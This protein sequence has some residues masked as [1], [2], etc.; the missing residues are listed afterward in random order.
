[1]ISKEDE[2]FGHGVFMHFLLE[3]LRG[4]ADGNRDGQITLGELSTYAGR[5]TKTH[6]ARKFSDYQQPALAG[7]F[8]PQALDYQLAIPGSSIRPGETITNS[9][10]M[11]LAYIPPGEFLMGTADEDAE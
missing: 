3:G 10:G 5:E 2:S 6:V 4:G 9:L 1:Q 8:A 11:K 7:N